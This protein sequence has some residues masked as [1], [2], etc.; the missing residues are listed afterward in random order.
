MLLGQNACQPL[1]IMVLFSKT[2][3]IHYIKSCDNYFFHHNLKHTHTH[4]HIYI[5]IYIYIHVL[6]YIYK[7]MF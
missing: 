7:Y 5:Y 2:F 3:S 4:T 6:I 1:Q